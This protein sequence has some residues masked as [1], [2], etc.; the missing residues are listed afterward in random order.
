[1][2]IK[3]IW[4]QNKNKKYKLIKAYD[5]LYQIRALRDFSNVKAGD[6]GGFVHSEKNLS[7]EGNAWIYDYA[8]VLDDSCV[9]EDATV[10]CHALVTGQVRLSGNVNVGGWARLYGNTEISGNF[11]I[12]TPPADLGEPI[13]DQP[14]N[15]DLSPR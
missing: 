12:M 14:G 11:S 5:G 9:S 13:P 6:L 4:I 2:N 10:G 1:M 3:K 15:G 7:H 8:K